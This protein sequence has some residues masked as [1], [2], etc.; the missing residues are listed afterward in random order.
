ML[1]I[2]VDEKFSLFIPPKDEIL[3]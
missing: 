3:V 1:L 2:Y